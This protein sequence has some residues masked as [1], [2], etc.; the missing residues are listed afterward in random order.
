M[1]DTRPCPICHNG[2]EQL[3]GE[4]DVRE[5]RAC[6]GSG[7]LGPVIEGEPVTFADPTPFAGRLELHWAGGTVRCEVGVNDTAAVIAEKMRAA[8]GNIGIEVSDA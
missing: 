2:W 6:G 3:P 1:P 8:L 5:C 4:D 7:L